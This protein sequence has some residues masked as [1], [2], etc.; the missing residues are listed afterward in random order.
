MVRK[1]KFKDKSYPLTRCANTEERLGYCSS[2]FANGVG[3]ELHVSAALTLERPDSHSAGSR[4]GLWAY[5]DGMEN[6][7]SVGIRSPDRPAYTKKQ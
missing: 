5:L 7:I 6:V 3:G 4:V 1:Y 2:T